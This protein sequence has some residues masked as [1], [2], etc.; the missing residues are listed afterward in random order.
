M[1]WAHQTYAEFLAARYLQDHEL[2][3]S[4]KLGL[5]VHP[6]DDEG[7]LIP[8]LY[9]TAAWLARMD[10][11]LFEEILS[12]DPEVLLRSDLSTTDPKVRERLVEALLTL[13]DEEKLLDKWEL[14]NRYKKLEHPHLAEQLR[15]FICDASKGFFARRVA[16]DIAEVCNQ[17]SL[18]N[19]LAE[20]VLT[21]LELRGIR[22]GAA[23]ALIKIGDVETRSRLL[24]LTKIRAEDDSDASPDGQTPCRQEA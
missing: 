15:R 18:Q 12:R 20:I 4:Q 23:H 14:Q 22:I 2:P 3:T 1:G 10:N 7:Q 6:N 9:E 19:D 11:Q 8:Q 5:L 16:I 13:F 21:K 17:Q 24:P